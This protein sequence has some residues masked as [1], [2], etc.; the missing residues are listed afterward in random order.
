MIKESNRKKALVAFLITIASVSGTNAQFVLALDQDLKIENEPVVPIIPLAGDIQYQLAGGS[1]QVNM[2]SKHAV[3]CNRID[4][5]SPVSNLKMRIVDPNG[6]NKGDHGGYS[7]MGLQSDIVYNSSSKAFVAISENRSKSICLSSVE[8]DV[9]FKS[10]LGDEQIIPT[11]TVTYDFINPPVNGYEAGDIMSYE[12]TYQ[13]TTGAP[14]LL[15]LIEYYPYTNNSD[16]FFN[17]GGNINCSILDANDDPIQG[18]FCFVSN[19]LVT[20][21][22]LQHTHKV[23][24]SIARQ[25]STLSSAGS[26]LQM[27][28]AVFPKV[29]TIDSINSS[30]SFSGFDVTSRHIEIVQ[31]SAN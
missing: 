18:E 5:Y 21:V 13:N 28:S 25:I 26:K 14:Q 24:L 16:A 8:F 9:I 3:I 23:K 10:G 20:D 19:G 1:G 22:T 17:Q 6:D 4:D 12:I 7:L 15:D 31:P 2:S 27:M 11:S 30:Y 29:T